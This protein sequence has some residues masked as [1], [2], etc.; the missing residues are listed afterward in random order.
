MKRNSEGIN[1]PCGTTNEQCSVRAKKRDRRFCALRT[2]QH[3]KTQTGQRKRGGRSATPL[4][5]GY[6]G[7]IASQHQGH[8]R[9]VGRVENMFAAYSNQK[10]AAYRDAGREHCKCDYI[11]PQ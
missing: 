7:V 6:P 10:L 9:D 3:D 2:R 5:G 11:G 1:K 4:A 8:K